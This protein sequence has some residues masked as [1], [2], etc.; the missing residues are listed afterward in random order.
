MTE[1]RIRLLDT[2]LSGASA[3]I[4]YG[5]NANYTYAMTQA[6]EDAG[7]DA[8][9]VGHGLGLGAER[10]GRAPACES[11]YRHMQAARMAARKARIGVSARTGTALEADI[12]TAQRAGMDFVRVGVDAAL[13]DSARGLV[14]HAV[15]TG[16]ETQL[17]LFNVYSLPVAELRNFAGTLGAWGLSTVVISDCAGGMV[18]AQVRNYVR[19]L[20]DKTDLSVGFAGRDNMQLAAGNA[21]AAIEAGARQ[22]EG[23]LKGMGTGAGTIQ[24]ESFAGALRKAGLSVQADPLELDGVA[25]K[26]I[27]N[28]EFARGRGHDDLIQALSLL[29]ESSAIEVEGVAGEYGLDP[30]A[31][32]IQAGRIGGGLPMDRNALRAVAQIAIWA[33]ED[34][35]SERDDSAVI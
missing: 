32:A 1:T 19:A 2:T 34:G 31:L 17:I 5:F 26:F 20:T 16:L 18:P 13:V 25:N 15:A 24:L 33:R 7:V 30:A 9:E 3:A 28:A 10:Q 14:D 12:E 6:M 8:I 23:A 29:P 11:D 21:F 4:G 27:T 22:V 35:V